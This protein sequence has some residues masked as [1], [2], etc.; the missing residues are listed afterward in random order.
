MMKQNA[1]K[2]LNLSRRKCSLVKSLNHSLLTKEIKS[3][4]HIA[5]K[6]RKRRRI[7]GLGCLDSHLESLNAKNLLKLKLRDSSIP[8]TTGIAESKKKKRKL[9][10]AK[11]QSLFKL[12]I[13]NGL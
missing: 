11:V 4:F 3:L 8:K 1:P 6:P 5:P 13:T 12:R 10:V 9:K 2:M 7:S